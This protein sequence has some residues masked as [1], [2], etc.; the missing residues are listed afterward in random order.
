MKIRK[1]VVLAGGRGTRLYPLTLTTNKHLLPLYNKPV[2]WYV[3]DTLVNAGIDRIMLVTNPEHVGDFARVL[4]SGERWKPRNGKGGQI[5]I[6][7]G[8]Q[9]KP[10]GIADGLYIAKDYVNGEPCLLYLGD[11]YIEDDLR[12]YI[13]S[14]KKG[15]TVFLKKVSDPERFGIATAD[16]SGN[17]LAIEEKP[18]NPK[19]NLAVVGIYL[20]DETVFEKMLG[21]KPSA[22]GEYEITYVNEKYRKEGKLRAEMLKKKWF[23]IGTFDSLAD[24]T[25]Y[26]KKH[27]RKEKG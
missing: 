27:S 7:Y 2:I 20:Y 12:P 14:F 15:A 25:H 5:Q 1:A 17:I 9:N 4:G 6:T 18:R 22:R 24:I 23:D 19:S 8:I 21:Q 3:I 11:N 16:A 26:L 10:S 13:K